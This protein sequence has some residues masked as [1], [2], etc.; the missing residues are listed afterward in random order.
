MTNSRNY[1]DSI[2]KSYRQVSVS[3][4]NYLDHVDRLVYKSIANDESKTLLD[5]GTGDGKRIFDLTDKLNIEVWVMENS[6]EMCSL[7]YRTIGK[8]HVMSSDISQLSTFSQTFDVITSLWNVFGHIEEIELAFS[9]IKN[10]LNPGG[11]F[12]FDVNNPFNIAEY[13]IISTIRNW[14]KIHIQREVLTFNLKNTGAETVVYF[15]SIG[16][17]KCMLRK[18]G[19]T[20][21]KVRFINYSTGSVT[22]IFRGQFYFECT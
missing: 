8:S 6:P 20:S 17:Y 13:G 22:N 19:F 16:F 3:R 18:A 1:Y 14:R 7:L 9:D 4:K 11:K 5:I 15:R 12:I 2:A 10:R 21:I